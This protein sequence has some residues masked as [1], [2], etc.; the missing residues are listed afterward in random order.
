MGV[1]EQFPMPFNWQPHWMGGGEFFLTN[2]H[3]LQQF[4]ELKVLVIDDLI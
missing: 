1:L 3:A 4:R 2:D